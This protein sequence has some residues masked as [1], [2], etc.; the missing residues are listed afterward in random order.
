MNLKK[1]KPNYSIISEEIGIENNKDKNNTWIID[2]IDGTIN[3]LHGVPH[4]AI[5]I[6][7]KS[8][9]QI[10]AGLIYDPIKRDVLCREE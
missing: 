9:D 6:A 7:L 5:S 1:A 8:H 2:P 10:I 4:F 3:Y